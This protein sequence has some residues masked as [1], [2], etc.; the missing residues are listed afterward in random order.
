MASKPRRNNESPREYAERI[1]EI[2]ERDARKDERRDKR[3][4]FWA[5]T[6]FGKNN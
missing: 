5:K 1:A 3:K 4:E 2:L 6:L